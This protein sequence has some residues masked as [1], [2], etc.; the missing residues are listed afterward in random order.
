MSFTRSRSSNDISASGSNP[1]AKKMRYGPNTALS[2]LESFIKRAKIPSFSSLTLTLPGKD[3]N[4]N[5]S[6][7]I[8]HYISSEYTIFGK[9]RKGIVQSI[10]D[11]SNYRD[12][13][14]RAAKLHSPLAIN[15]PLPDDLS[16]ALDVIAFSPPSDIRSFWKNQIAEFTTLA[17]ATLPLSNTWYKQ[18]PTDIRAATGSINIALFSALIEMLHL[19][20]NYWVAQFVHGFPITGFLSQA[21][22]FPKRVDTRLEV[23]N[24]SKLFLSA[25]S[26]FIKRS[27]QR[28]ISHQQLMWDETILEVQRGWFSNPRL[29]NRSGRIVESPGELINPAFR[30]PVS[31]PDKVRLIDDLCHSETNLYA[32][33][34]TN[35]T[36]PNWD[37]A[38]E[39]FLRAKPAHRAW[40]F[41]KV[42]HASAYKNLP[43]R[44]SDRPYANVVVKN[45]ND[46]KWYAFAPT[47]QLFGSTASVLHYN[48]FSRLL[49]TIINRVFAIPTIGYYDDYG[50]YVPAE[51]GDEAL[52]LIKRICHLLGVT[53]KEE[54]CYIGPTNTFL[55]LSGIF[56]DRLNNFSLTVALTPEKSLKWKR[57]LDAIVGA[58]SVSRAALE[59]LIGRLGFAQ[60]G[61]FSKFARCM[62]QPLYAKLYSNPFYPNIHGRTLD[63]FRW[64][65]EAIVLLPPRVI[66]DRVSKPA[67]LLYTDA[68][69]ENNA[70]MLG[71]VLFDERGTQSQRAI[72][73]MLASACTP[74]MVNLFRQTSTIF[75]LELTAVALAIF[76]FR[77]RLTGQS[78]IIFID[79]NAVLGAIVRGQT[80][81]NPAHSF[82]SAIWM[83]AC[84]FSI[85]IWFDRVPSAVN[86]ADLPTRFRE[87]EFPVM[88]RA[89][90]PS[91]DEWL[92]FVNR[93]FTLTF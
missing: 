49:V 66:F 55:G 28:N 6:L 84:T 75:G 4:P 92:E 10:V 42:D 54:K 81:G 91:L 82:V 27:K 37:I 64:W 51:L 43:I 61:V 3:V 1:K 67:F 89:E 85:S 33:V 86:I 70:G 2:F 56:P 24:P 80:N 79:N 25:S 87:P 35:I 21:G 40:V 47:T 48:V 11:S 34:A 58:R 53:L 15:S 20:N 22:V 68:S 5:D 41:G 88:N 19:G 26:R 78:I 7:N 72:D 44:P 38:V 77:F 65:A 12:H 8:P 50:F 73:T 52:T 74:A 39:L 71:A 69:W 31:Q 59:S 90:F 29:L 32:E 60:S 83:I 23:D 36:L 62:L 76:Y 45:P 16:T 18:T 46:A 9:Q 14:E 17:E 57:T 30:F 13:I 63:T 93:V